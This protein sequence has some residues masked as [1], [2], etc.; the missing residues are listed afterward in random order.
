MRKHIIKKAVLLLSLWSV[1]GTAYAQTGSENYVYSKTY[2]SDPAVA[3]AKISETV[4]YFDGLGRPKQVVNVKAATGGKDLV[5]PITYDGFGRQ[6][7]DIL[8]VPANSQISGIHAGITN[9][10][11]A[12]SF[13]GAP[14]AFSEK[15]IESSPLDR[16]LQ[17]GQPGD[18]WKLGGGHTQKYN[19]EVT[20]SSPSSSIIAM[21]S[22]SA[23]R[24]LVAG[25]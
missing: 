19:Y 1:W 17:Q 23:Y 18:P 7:K 15:E 2:L 5:V 6:T 22:F 9:E 4:T 21:A 14:N 12:N 3:N 24:R 25:V 20:L 13:Y 8:P 10:S 11:A 16:V